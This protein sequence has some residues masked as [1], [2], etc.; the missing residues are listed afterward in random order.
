[1]SVFSNQY[2][3]YVLIIAYLLRG[4][5][6]AWKQYYSSYKL[7]T[8]RTLSVQCYL[9]LWVPLIKLIVCTSKNGGS[10]LTRESVVS[11]AQAAVEA[12]QVCKKTSSSEGL[13]ALG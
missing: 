7:S 9:Y 10:S 12:S 4:S 11:V 6:H 13:T 3:I 2:E 5:S 1:M 8:K